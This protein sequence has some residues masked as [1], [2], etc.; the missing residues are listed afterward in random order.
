MNDYTIRLYWELSDKELGEIYATA[1]AERVL[2]IV[3]YDCQ[4]D[5]ERFLLFARRV[6]VFGAVMD[7]DK[8]MGFFYLTSF[9]G[10]TARVHFCL[11]EAGREYREEAGRAVLDWCFKSF[12]YG[13]LVSLIGIVPAINQGVIKYAR[14]M[15]GQEMGTIPGFCW[16]ERL[17]RSVG[18]VQFI[19]TKGEYHGRH[20]QN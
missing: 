12:E 20:V 1:Q 17:K 8:T 11:F 9:E 4:V 19:F 14:E 13:R 5:L 6:E 3:A 2:D 15:G 18:G 7:G 16:I 10:S